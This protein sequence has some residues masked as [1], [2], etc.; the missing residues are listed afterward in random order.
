MTLMFTIVWFFS[1]LIVCEYTVQK[2]ELSSDMEDEEEEEVPPATL[3]PPQIGMVLPLTSRPI[4]DVNN[5]DT[6][7]ALTLLV[8]WQEGH[9]ACTH[10]IQKAQKFNLV[11]QYYQYIYFN[12]FS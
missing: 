7:S 9:P 6:F 1:N 4:S 2:V 8:G 10:I 3:Q 11:Y 5:M 12:Y